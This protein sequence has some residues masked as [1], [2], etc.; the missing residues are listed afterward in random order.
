MKRS[1]MRAMEYHRMTTA[2]NMMAIR[3]LV[4]TVLGSTASAL[5]TN[6]HGGGRVCQ[7]GYTHTHSVHMLRL[8]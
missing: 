2:K 8:T 4:G 1:P 6:L 3:T 7:V 5:A